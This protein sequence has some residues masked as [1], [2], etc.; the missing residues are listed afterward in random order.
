MTADAICTKRRPLETLL[1]ALTEGSPD[2][3]VLGSAFEYVADLA[4]WSSPEFGARIKQIWRWEDWPGAQG[5]DLGI[6]RVI[7]TVDG[8]LWALQAKGYSSATSLKYAGK[9]GIATFLAAASTGQFAMQLVVTSSDRVADNARQIA[10]RQLVPTRILDRSWLDS[11][12]LDWPTGITDLRDAVAA[13]ARG[14]GPAQ[15]SLA[16]G[17]HQLAPHQETA[18]KDVVTCLASQ[19]TGDARAKLLMPCGTGKTV[20]CHAVTESLGARQIL[21]LVPSLSLLAQAMRAW[22]AQ[23]LGRLRVIAVCSDE[24]VV[25]R[26]DAIVMNP[27]E[28]MAPVTTESKALASFL[29]GSGVQAD[30]ELWPTVVFS[31]YH[32]WDC[33]TDR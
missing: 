33:C 15:V 32:S 10:A 12:D 21:V 14:Q 20:T 24:S 30:G 13:A 7:S 6:D 26:D 18:V 22:Q 11:L 8:E 2:T 4:L 17:R 23:S 29:A 28:I 31:T 27:S 16:A 19:S 3:S 1:R 9:G 25:A 5:R